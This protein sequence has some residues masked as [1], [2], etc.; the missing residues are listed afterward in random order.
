MKNKKDLL[1]F[2]KLFFKSC[3]DVH[4]SDYKRRNEHH[5]LANQIGALCA[6]TQ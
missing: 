1:T 2:F 3:F 5:N 6:N 4:S